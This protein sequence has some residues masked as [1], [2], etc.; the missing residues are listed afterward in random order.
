[1]THS[2]FFLEFP[3]EHSRVT[4][5]R[6]IRSHRKSSASTVR[7][8]REGGPCARA[9]KFTLR[10]CLVRNAT[11]RPRKVH[12][13]LSPAPPSDL[14]LLIIN[15]APSSDA[16]PCS[17]TSTTADLPCVARPCQ[18]R[19]NARLCF[20]SSLPLLNSCPRLEFFNPLFRLFLF[21]SLPMYWTLEAF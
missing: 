14:L 21:K 10:F 13:L 19:K 3:Q 4:Q 9:S 8:A 1:M 15:V 5:S 17:D 12:F 20:H 18:I 2:I 7:S 16:I 6:G 11:V